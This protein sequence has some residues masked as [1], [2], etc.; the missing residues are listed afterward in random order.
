MFA[1]HHAAIPRNA[2]VSAASPYTENRES[3]ADV[4]MAYHPY[5]V[6][7]TPSQYA[8]P[9]SSTHSSSDWSNR[10]RRFASPLA[11]EKLHSPWCAPSPLLLSRDDVSMETTE[12]ERWQVG[13][14]RAGLVSRLHQ[15]VRGPERG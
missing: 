14:V 8:P 6:L 2:P 9:A 7:S 12:M 10:P 11:Q 1:Q 15:G 4:E 13:R 3:S 5:I